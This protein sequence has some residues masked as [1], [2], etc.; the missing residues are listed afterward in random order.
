MCQIATSST[1]NSTTG[2]KLKPNLHGEGPANNCLGHGMICMVMT[3]NTSLAQKKKKK[4]GMSM[5]L[6]RSRDDDISE[7]A[8]EK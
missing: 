4:H 7:R 3:S 5:F 8:I 2:L 6:K 1:T